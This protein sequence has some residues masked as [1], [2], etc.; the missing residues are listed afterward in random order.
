MTHMGHLHPARSQLYHC[1]PLAACHDEI[2]QSV[3]RCFWNISHPDVIQSLRTTESTV[4]TRRIL[5]GESDM[6]QSLSEVPCVNCSSDWRV[7]S[8]EW[9]VK[10]LLF[11]LA[12]NNVLV[13]IY[14]VS[15]AVS[16]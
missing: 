11:P 7:E 15:T 6:E 16:S 4:F 12:K 14:N 10:S 5:L 3:S 8:G 1:L 13:K 2:A 9:R